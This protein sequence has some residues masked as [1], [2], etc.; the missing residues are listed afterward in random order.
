MNTKNLYRRLER[1]EA[2]ALAVRSSGRVRVLFVDGDP[3]NPTTMVGPDGQLVWW[4]P[5]EG[6][7]MGEPLKGNLGTR[8]LRTGGLHEIV[9]M[10]GTGMD[11]PTT[12]IGPNGRLVWL[13]PPEGC[14]EGETV[15]ERGQDHV[16]KDPSCALRQGD[17]NPGPP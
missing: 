9:V 1:L 15:D 16:A 17:H 3:K 13:K 12:V 4:R 8:M 6:R 10:F 5:P 2:L 11:G 7:K 14:K